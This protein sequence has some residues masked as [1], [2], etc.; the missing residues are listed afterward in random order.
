MA[1]ITGVGTAVN[2]SGTYRMEVFTCAGVSVIYEDFSGTANGS[3]SHTI[4]DVSLAA[5]LGSVKVQIRDL[6]LFG[7]LS[8]SVCFNH[9]CSV[10]S[11]IS[12]VTGNSNC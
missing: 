10:T 9:N 11:S 5:N 12:G 6:N 3:L 1:S 7:V 4:T 8:E 2:G